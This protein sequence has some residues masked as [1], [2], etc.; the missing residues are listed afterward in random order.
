MESVS[1]ARAFP[2]SRRRRH[3]RSVPL[4]MRSPAVLCAS[5]NASVR[6][7]PMLLIA[8]ERLFETCSSNLRGFVERLSLLVA[9]A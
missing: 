5:G 6:A 3:S 1:P 8:R 2:V 7:Y 9:A 4:A